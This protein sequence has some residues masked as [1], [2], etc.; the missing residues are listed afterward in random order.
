MPRIAKSEREERMDRIAKRVRHYYDDIR[1]DRKLRCETAANTLGFTCYPTF[2]N[3]LN[4]PSDFTLG[5]L[6]AI[7]N[8]MNISIE[9]LIGK[10]E[11][12][13]DNG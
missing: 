6:F 7:A 9:T 3:R 13:H 11:P 10:E 1:R 4:R 5:E 8:V 12:H 2:R